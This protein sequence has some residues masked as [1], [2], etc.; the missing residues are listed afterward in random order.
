[1]NNISYWFIFYIFSNYKFADDNECE[2]GLNDCDEHAD[3]LN[4]LGSYEC[5][6]FDGFRGDGY[7]CRGMTILILCK[8]YLSLQCT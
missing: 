5:K 4:T 6:C 3:C 1:M 2:M 8:T 7:E